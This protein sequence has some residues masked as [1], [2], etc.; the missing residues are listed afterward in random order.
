MLQ[1]VDAWTNNFAYV[2]HRA[3]GTGA[4]AFLLVPPGWDGAAPDG[5]T[6][7]RVPTAVASIV[8]RWAVDGEDDLPAVRALQQRA[9]PTPPA[10]PAPGCPR[11]T[12]RVRRRP[13]VLRAAAVWM[14]AFPP[15][16]RDLDYQQRFA[17]LGLFEADVALRG[18]RLGL[19]A[20]CGRA[21][22]PGASTWSRHSNAVR[23]VE[24]LWK[25]LQALA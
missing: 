24:D 7:I 13:R 20:A 12:P 2:G 5:A 3:T 11:P 10:A 23:P 15:A 22:R 9:D 18:A 25:V 4:G 6:V 1:F 16:A 21:C 17:P 14:Q 19:A 8:G